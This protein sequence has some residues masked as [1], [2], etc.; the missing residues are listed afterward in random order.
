MGRRTG[1][2]SDDARAFEEAMRG[3]RALPAGPRRLVGAPA[4]PRPRQ[5][6]PPGPSRPRE[7]PPRPVQLAGDGASGRAV[8]VSARELR[9]LRSGQRRPEARLD[10]HGMARD[11]ALDAVERFLRQCRGGGFRAVIVIH[12]RGLNSEAGAPVLRPALHAWLGG[13][14]GTR[15]GV[16]AFAPAPARWGGAGATL[17]LL[18]R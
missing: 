15:A 18:R 16:M 17:V 14:A 5:A 10:L 8:D 1:E 4:A 12:G 3:A 9:R 13:A 2:P 7:P 6:P 11:Q